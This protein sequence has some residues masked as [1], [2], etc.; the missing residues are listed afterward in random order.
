MIPIPIWTYVRVDRPCGG[1]EPPAAVYYALRDRYTEHRR[2]ILRA[3]PAFLRPTPTAA[4]ILSTIQ[5]VSPRR[6]RLPFV[7]RKQEGCSSNWQV[8]RR[9]LGVN[10]SAATISPSRWRR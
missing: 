9:M 4:S 1:R 8:Q 2:G 6:S 5:D 7:G 10:H 3:S